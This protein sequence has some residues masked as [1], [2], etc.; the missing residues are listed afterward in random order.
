MPEPWV[1]ACNLDR[2]VDQ[3]GV[4]QA[5]VARE[6]YE[7]VKP[8]M[9]LVWQGK[10][11][12]RLRGTV[13]VG[14]CTLIPARVFLGYLRGYFLYREV[15]ENDQAFW[16]HFLED[17][18]IR[19]QALPTLAEYDRL[20]DALAWHEE[21]RPHLSHRQDGKRDFIGTLDSI[22]HFKAL[23]LDRLKEAF[24]GSYETGELPP[25]AKPYERVFREL[26]RAIGFLL[27]EGEKV[28]LRDEGRVLAFLE[29]AGLFLGEPNPI[30]LLFRRSD[31]ALSDL[32]WRLKGRR[33]PETPSTHRHRQVRVELLEAPP[34][35]EEIRPTVSHE[36]L[37]EG[38]KVYGKVVLEDGRF[39]RFAWVP[40]YTPQGEPLPEVKEVAFS[41]GER[42][43]FRLHH[44]AFAVRFSKSS[45]T[46]GE[47]LEVR[48]IGFDPEC[49]PLRYQLASRGE[50]R[51]TPEAL[52]QELGKELGEP[53]LKDELVLEVRIAAD[54]WRRVATLPVEV[55]VD[56]QGWTT[57]EGVFVR[58]HPP[59]FAVRVQIYAGPRLLREEH[60][61]TG[62][63]GT[64]VAEPGL[65]PLHVRVASGDEALSLV[66]SPRGW[67]QGWWRQGLGWGDL[68][69]HHAS[70]LAKE[71]G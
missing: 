13:Q 49:H 33:P 59:G 26:K 61:P 20:W 65:V 68:G 44:K 48:S 57:P 10:R 27:S 41:E 17:L 37:V 64:R 55:R 50:P 36:P 23:R 42:V 63:Q 38:W 24:V 18:G 28:D 16:P 34:G 3:H 66:L 60:V 7:G 53:A 51:K 47:P 35:L 25:E 39:Q 9:R 43:R 56:L 19:G 30:R 5:Q 6:D 32:Y 31:Q 69:R 1:H 21:T 12:E 62:D 40:R 2:A 71:T 15:P 8:L 22:F 46:L 54:T 45:W 4:V 14:G 70:K 67:P 58:T 52:V 29:E 11:W